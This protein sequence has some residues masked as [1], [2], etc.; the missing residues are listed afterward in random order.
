ME[1]KKAK[2]I[3]MRIYVVGRITVILIAEKIHVSRVF[4]VKRSVNCLRFLRVCNL[5]AI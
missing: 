1:N 2:P 4:I 5:E 3:K